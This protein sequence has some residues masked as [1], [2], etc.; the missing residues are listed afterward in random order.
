MKKSLKRSSFVEG[1]LI[2]TIAI[3]FT[4]ILGMLYVIPFYGMLDGKGT[5]L[6]G[7]AYSIYIVFLDI[8]SAGLP[9]AISKII[10]E[11]SALGKNEAKVRS[12]KIGRNIM[13]LIAFAV[14]LFLFIFARQVAHVMLGNLE[15]GNTLSDVALAIRSVSFAILI[16]PFLSVT[17]GYLQGHKIINI[18]SYSQVIEQI[19]RI[20]VILLGT[21]FVLNVIGGKVTTAVCISVFAAFLAG[22]VAYIYIRIKIHQDKSIDIN[23]KYEKDDVSNKEIVKKIFSYAIPFIIIN[24]VGSIY[25]FIDLTLLVR[26]MDYLKIS[27]DLVEFASTSVT[28]WAPKINMIV[29]SV[30]MGMSTSFIPTMVTAYTLKNWQEVNNKFN[31][32]LQILIFVSLPMT[33]GLSM[34]AVPIWSIFYGYNINGVYILALNVFTGLFINIYMIASSALQGLNKFKI[35]YVSTISGFVTNALLD[36][37]LMVLYSKIGI[38]VY[39][40]AVTASIIGYSLSIMITLLSLRKQCNMRYGKTWR[41]VCKMVVPMLL[42]M[43]T[44][45]GLSKIVPLNYYSRLSCIVY[46]AIVS[47]VGGLVYALVAAKMKLF[48]ETFG[49]P[50]VSRIVRKVTFGKVNLY[51]EE[52]TE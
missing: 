38:P 52:E 22:L 50:M 20:A 25:N 48:S 36:V 4:K 17:K 7:Y 49:K 19:V 12:Y 41:T 3:V 28:T 45:F 40:G 5:A 6:Y 1:T 13:V 33:V 51:N 31:Q 11:Y 9:I 37:P 44:V 18:P 15:G 16:V 34:L 39:L 30:A 24:I 43:L 21:Y 23:K 29:T 46:V 47:I 27:P 14:W 8:S 32:A 42:M 2:A 26:T 35:V 10:S